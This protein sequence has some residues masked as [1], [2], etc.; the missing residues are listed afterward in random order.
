L[1][2]GL[3]QFSVASHRLQRLSLQSMIRIGNGSWIAR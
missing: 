3:T 1:E 2:T